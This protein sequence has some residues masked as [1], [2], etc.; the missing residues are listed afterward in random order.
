MT[1]VGSLVK[2]VKDWSGLWRLIILSPLEVLPLGQGA[3]MHQ[4]GT[5]WGKLA[6]LLP[7][8]SNSGDESR[9]SGQHFVTVQISL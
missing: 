3:D 9:I 5:A 8:G 1:L 4:E 2:G 6:L 7:G